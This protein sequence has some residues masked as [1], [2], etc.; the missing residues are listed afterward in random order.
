V[1]NILLALSAL[2]P[3]QMEWKLA[4]GLSRLVQTESQAAGD[5]S[6][7]A[8]SQPQPNTPPFFWAIT[9]VSLSAFFAA[10]L[11]VL[12]Y[13]FCWLGA[14]LALS[15]GSSAWVAG[16]SLL[17][18]FIVLSSA[19][20]CGPRFGGHRKIAYAFTAIGCYAA[21]AGAATALGRIGLKFEWALSSRYTTFSIYLPIGVVGL[22]ALSFARFDGRN[23]PVGKR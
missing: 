6:G 19:E 10:P 7:M 4:S 22:A 14:P 12:K 18:I 16:V 1:A 20:L 3:T 17:L 5:G 8:P 11:L 23:V 13:F 2:S 9:Q 15:L 21:L